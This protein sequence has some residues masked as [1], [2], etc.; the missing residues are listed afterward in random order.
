MCS[1]FTWGTVSVHYLLGLPLVYALRSATPNGFMLL[2]VL[3]AA[4]LHPIGTVRVVMEHSATQP[5]LWPHSHRHI[6]PFLLRQN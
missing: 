6:V 2:V 1:S 5:P 3:L 4:L